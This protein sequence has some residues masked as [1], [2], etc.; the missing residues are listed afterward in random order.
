LGGLSRRLVAA[1]GGFHAEALLTDEN[2]IQDPSIGTVA[3]LL[4]VFNG[5]A[6]LREQIASL[7]EQTHPRIDIWASDDGSTDN[8]AAI[9]RES[10]DR[11]RK[12]SFE[13]LLGPR[14]GFAENFRSLLV[15]PSIRA[16]YFAFCDQDDIWM[17]DKLA[18]AIAWLATQGN[19]PA[20]YCSRTQ[21]IDVE[22]RHIGLSPR[23]A[24]Q[25]SFRNALVQSIAGGN[26]MVMNRAARELL[27]EASRRT[28]F[29][30]HD[31]WCY[32]VVSG[33]GG[34]V[35]HSPRPRILYRQHDANLVGANNYSM[36][37]KLSRYAFMHKG[38]FANW[39][40]RN[41][42]GLK[43]CQ[44]LLTDDALRVIDR[45][46]LSRGKSVPG[47]LRL[48]YR[49][50]VYRQTTGGTLGLYLASALGKL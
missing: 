6:Y 33:A 23:F 7:A 5:E 50:G 37:A 22:G 19:R 41:I 24:K 49:S 27:A 8:S 21:L 36:R 43:A 2:S 48:L 18:A 3:I 34:E 25:P 46:E 14:T 26:T 28:S 20:L 1:I 39:T 30:S 40:S 42:A 29:I 35:H 13:V 44:D 17:P 45:V 31:W 12:G 32:L 9:L 47:R 15:D 10:A 4:G 38:G 11:W 16:D